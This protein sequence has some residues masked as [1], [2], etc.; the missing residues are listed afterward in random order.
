MMKTLDALKSFVILE[1][2]AHGGMGAV[3]VGYNP[4]ARRLVAIKTLFKAQG[5]DKKYV[6]RFRWEGDIYKRLNHPN[7]V[8]YVDMDEV[9]GVNFIAMEHVRGKPLDSVLAEKGRFTWE[10]ALRITGALADAMAHY[11]DRKLLHRDLK[12]QN[13]LLNQ[14]GIVK[15]IDFG[16][17]VSL[18]QAAQPDGSIVGTF[19]YSSPEQNQGRKLDERSDLYALGLMFYE[20]L[21]G[22]RVFPQSSLA[23]VS[24]A[25]LKAD[26]PYPSAVESD[27][28]KGLDKIVMKLIARDANAR[29]QKAKE[30]LADLEL[31]KE[32]PQGF[33]PRSAFDDEGVTAKWEQ[34]KVCVAKKDFDQALRLAQVVLSRKPDSAEVHALVGKAQAGAGAGDEAVASFAKAMELEPENDQHRLDCGIALYGL[35]RFDEALEEFQKILDLVPD[36]P[37]AKRYIGL[38]QQAKAAASQ[39]PAGSTPTGGTAVPTSNPGAVRVPSSPGAVRPPS[40]PGKVKTIT[41]PTISA[42]PVP[43]TSKVAY[44]WWGWA[45][46]KSGRPLSGV[47]F[48]LLEVANIGLIALPWT[49]FWPELLKPGGPLAALFVAGGPLA[50]AAAF[51]EWTVSGPAIFL[52]LIL[53]LVLPSKLGPGNPA[54]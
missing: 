8:G 9:D 16:I 15:L 4:A 40:G 6:D 49:P 54:S 20:M 38:C 7:I 53:E 17:A 10:D 1:E 45:A 51:K 13:V 36:N 2:L 25:Q 42:P 37:Y 43:A 12:P 3:H 46:F 28:P 5:K 48:S 33:D 39:P 14:D 32:D 34:A 22:K 35:K 21:T 29:Y 24:S 52:F 47:F 44:V 50:T 30:V 41:I 26:I 18:E 31:C 27:V 11:H 19:N 23:E